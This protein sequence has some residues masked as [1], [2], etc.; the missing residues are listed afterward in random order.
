[1]GFLDWIRGTPTTIDGT[2]ATPSEPAAPEEAVVPA[3]PVG[4]AGQSA[5]VT[6]ENAFT[7][8]GRGTV[9]VGTAHGGS[10]ATGQTV[11]VERDGQPVLRTT[12]V[13]IDAKGKQ[14][15]T[16]EPGTEVGVLLADVARSDVP[17]GS[18]L[19]VAP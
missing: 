10:L 16:A 15:D 18:V 3:A 11:E 9:V 13:G 4:G 2:G 8:T 7:I 12:I 5:E 1:M 19:R 14:T 6:V 17:A